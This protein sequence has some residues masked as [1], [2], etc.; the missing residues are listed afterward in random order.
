MAKIADRPRGFLSRMAPALLIMVLAPTFTEL[1]LGGTRLSALIGFPPILGMEIAVWGGGALMLRALARKLGLG[2]GSL[3]LFGLIIAIAE[4]FVIQQ[5]S[6]APLVIKLKGVEWARAGGINYVYAL[7]ALVYEAVWVVLFPTLVAEMVF[8]QRKQETWLSKTGL[9]IVMIL[10]PI[11]A[12]MA[13]YGWTRIARVQTFHLP[14]YNPPPAAIL[15]ALAVIA[16]LFGWAIKFPPRFGAAAR[17]PAPL[18]LG[19]GGAV[20]ATLWFGMV[21]L[22]FGL[23]PQL[24]APGIFAAGLIL[25]LIV[26]LTLPRWATHTDWTGRHAYGLF[27]GTLTGAMLASFVGFQGAAAADFWFKAVTNL[28]AFALMILL[29]RRIAPGSAQNFGSSSLVR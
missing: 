28:I 10:F 18:L 16:A 27:F 11:G 25:T 23:A 3:L 12:I 26:L 22:A 1:L 5:T 8:P 29:G 20:W 24:S 2:W 21:V 15:A 13:W 19:L 17:P 6:L 14:I 7:W 9:A 4:E